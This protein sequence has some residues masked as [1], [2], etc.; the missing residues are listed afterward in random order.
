MQPILP[1]WLLLP[2]TA[3]ALVFLGWRLL[4]ERRHP[5]SS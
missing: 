2:L 4:V 1:W 3:A 5:G